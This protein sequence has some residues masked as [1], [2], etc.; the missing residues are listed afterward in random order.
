MQEGVTLVE[1]AIVMVIAGFLLGSGILMG[2]SLLRGMHAREVVALIQDLQTAT[3]YFKDK[4]H[5]LPG[6]LPLAGNDISGVTPGCNLPLNRSRI[7]DG[8]IN[9]HT[10]SIPEESACVA[11]ELVSAGFIK[12]GVEAMKSR[13]GPV[14]LVANSAI[15]PGHSKTLLPTS[16]LNVIELEQ[17]PWDIAIQVDR[18]LDDGVLTLGEIRHFGWDGNQES[19]VPYLAVPL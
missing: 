5:Y 1:M 11:S 19:S 18:E 17:L 3:R 7:G 9:N 4:Y 13:F 16:I 2:H 12:G 8:L 6:D 15:V 10:A 14:T